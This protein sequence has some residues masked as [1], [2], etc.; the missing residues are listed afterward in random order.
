[1]TEKWVL[2]YTNRQLNM[3]D[4]MDTKEQLPVRKVM[5]A[6][7]KREISQVRRSIKQ[8]EKRIE[9]HIDEFYKAHNARNS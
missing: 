4:F 2:W 7:T 1:M 3:G 6:P 8:A 5:T 9:H